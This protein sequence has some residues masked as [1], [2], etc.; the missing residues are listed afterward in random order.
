MGTLDALLS[1]FL[2][3]EPLILEDSHITYRNPD[4]DTD[5]TALINTELATEGAESEVNIKGSGR[6]VFY[7]N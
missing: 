7:A 1:F 3:G 2:V 4:K 6:L 5:I